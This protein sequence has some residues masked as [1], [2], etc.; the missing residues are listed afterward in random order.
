MNYSMNKISKE[1]KMKV[2]ISFD[3]IK[4]CETIEDLRKLDAE[5]KDG[6]F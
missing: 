2:E 3:K 4:Q 5:Y 6:E 1:I